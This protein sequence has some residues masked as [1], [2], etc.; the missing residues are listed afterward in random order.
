M[1]T[2]KRKRISDDPLEQ[3]VEDVVNYYL[4]SGD[5]NGYDWSYRSSLPEQT[6]DLLKK[7]VRPVIAAGRLTIRTDSQFPFIKRLPDEP[8]EEQ[9][10][11]LDESNMHLLRLFPSVSEMKGRIGSR[12]R[13]RPFTKELAQGH[14]QLEPRFFDPIVLEQYI[15]DPR[16]SCRFSDTFGSIHSHEPGPDRQAD[17]VFLQTFGFAYDSKWNRA[18]AVYIRYLHDLSPEHQHLWKAREL[19][20]DYKLHPDYYRGS[21]IGMW[22]EHIGILDA[23]LMEEKAINEM[24]RLMDR[25]PLFRTEFRDGRP[26]GL[27]F[28][29]RPTQ[30]EYQRF[31]H[32]LDKLIS[33]N[34]DLKF[35]GSDVKRTEEIIGRDGQVETRNKGSLR[36]LE[37]WLRARF[38]PKQG[39]PIAEAI[40]PLKRV[41]RLRQKPAHT[42]EQDQFDRGIF[43]EEHDLIVAV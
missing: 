5:F 39:D 13:G 31:I 20:G 12:F 15:N 18:V 23:L 27:R 42:L 29:I 32:V 25:P 28:L 33:E 34:I 17:R 8:I 24:A 11:R 2:R 38:H 43:K 1:P 21:V 36:I 40:A 9:L 4:T 41:R 7:M 30:R 14:A 22:P 10:R 6:P 26:D 35:F 3:L 16:Y 37:E 19:R